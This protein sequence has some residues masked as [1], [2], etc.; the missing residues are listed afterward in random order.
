MLVVF[1]SGSIRRALHVRRCI[2]LVCIPGQPVQRKLHWFDDVARRP[3]GERSR[4]LLLP[5][6][7]CA[8]YKRVGGQLKTWATTIKAD[9]EPLSGP[10]EKGLGES[11]A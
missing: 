9:L 11:L 4:D 6:L 1:V 5:T 8:W 10:M 2:H 7:L 3:K